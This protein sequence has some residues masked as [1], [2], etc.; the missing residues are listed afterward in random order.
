LKTIEVTEAPLHGIADGANANADS[1]QS[2]AELVND[3]EFL[4]PEYLE[5]SGLTSWLFLVKEFVESCAD[6]LTACKKIAA[7]INKN[8]IFIKSPELDCCFQQR[9]G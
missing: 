9:I 1:L 3:D 5:L 6:A 7:K 4:K 8:L 2:A